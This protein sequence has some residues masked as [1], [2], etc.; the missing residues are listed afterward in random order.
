MR[1]PQGPPKSPKS[2]QVYLRAPMR[3]PQVCQNEKN[4]VKW[5]H[6]TPKMDS[7]G[8]PNEPRALQKAGPQSVS[9]FY[10]KLVPEGSQNG[11]Q[12]APGTHQKSMEK[13]DQRRKGKS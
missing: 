2:A 8:N 9:I 11:V 1:H 4:E 13:L 3:Q 12:I 7:K 10:R 5:A 6:E